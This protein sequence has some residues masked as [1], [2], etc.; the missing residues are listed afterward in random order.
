[1]AI[2]LGSPDLYTVGWIAALPIERSAAIAMLDER[3][4]A[5]NGFEQH[6]S[7]HNLY[8]WGHIG[9]HNIVI[10]SLPAGICGQNAAAGT[11]SQ[12]L[13]SLPGIRIGLLV[14]IG[15]AIPNHGPVG[16]KYDIRLGDIVVGQPSGPEGGVIQYDM[17]KMGTGEWERI[18]TVDKPPRVLLN[19]LSNLQAEHM[20]SPSRVPELLAEMIARYPLMAE[21]MDKSTGFI[22]PGISN[23]QLFVSD[24]KHVGGGG[25]DPCSRCDSSQQVHRDDRHTTDPAIHYGTIASGNTLVKDARFRDGIAGKA[26]QQCICFEMEAAG[27]N[28]DFPCLIIRGICDYSDSHKNDQW[29]KY[30]SATSAAYAKE[31]LGFVPVKSVNTT[32][33]AI[34]AMKSS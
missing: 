23:D 15:G 28:R 5:P 9:N 32:P 18:G 27:I 8:S 20:I 4:D 7:D 29:Q 33:R 17:G 34:D 16:M 10:A 19:A 1:M 2:A 6:S 12:L 22:H 11:V 3:H 31:L 24:Y 21:S 13:S 26:G 30:A 14:G 25:D